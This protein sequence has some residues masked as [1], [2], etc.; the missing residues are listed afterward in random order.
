MK[1]Q[2]RSLLNSQLGADVLEMMLLIPGV[3]IFGGLAMTIFASPEVRLLWMGVTLEGLVILAD[4]ILF[5]RWLQHDR[6]NLTARRR[7]NPDSDRVRAKIR[8][9]DDR[10]P[11]VI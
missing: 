3:M 6:R 11:A 7:N 5:L 8:V 9:P 1:S 10:L 4:V 2:L